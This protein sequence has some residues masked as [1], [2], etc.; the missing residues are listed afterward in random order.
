MSPSPIWVK[1]T[2]FGISKLSSETSLRTVCGTTC[3]QAPEVLGLLPMNMRTSGGK[4]YTKIVDIWALGAVVH[5]I[6][7][8]EIPFCEKYEDCTITGIDSAYTT[9]SEVDLGLV[10][11][12]CRKSQP[13]PTDCLITNNASK[14]AI[15]FVKSMMVADP[16][17]RITAVEALD[18]RWL[19]ETESFAQSLVILIL[20]PSFFVS[21]LIINPV[22]RFSSPQIAFPA[23]VVG[24]SPAVVVGA[25]LNV[26]GQSKTERSGDIECEL[27]HLSL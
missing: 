24:A 21:L 17:G 13:F 22:A 4:S 7:T 26:I 2:D 10:A 6:L 12:Y 11:D 20:L 5:K 25:S 3:Y 9:S 1:I 23:A 27:G 15:D 8:S 18:S 19:K 14:Y 16:R